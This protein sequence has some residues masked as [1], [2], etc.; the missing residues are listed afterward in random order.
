MAEKK[1]LRYLN[2]ICTFMDPVLSFVKSWSKI[3]TTISVHLWHISQAKVVKTG[4]SPVQLTSNAFKFL[5]HL[6]SIVAQIIFQ[7]IIS[8]VAWSLHKDLYEL[9]EKLLTQPKWT[10]EKS[11]IPLLGIQLGAWPLMPKTKCHST[12]YFVLFFF[13]AQEWAPD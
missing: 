5:F 3:R 7:K 1:Q 12:T 13:E 2:L 6:S 4:W 8:L 10:S 9:A 11:L